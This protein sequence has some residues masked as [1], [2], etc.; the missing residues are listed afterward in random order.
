MESTEMT[1]HGGVER[2]L[3]V[4][5]GGLI[6]MGCIFSGHHPTTQALVISGD[7]ERSVFEEAGFVSRS[8]ERECVCE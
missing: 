5:V 7:L 6:V 8:R 4:L 2:I 3:E 1:P